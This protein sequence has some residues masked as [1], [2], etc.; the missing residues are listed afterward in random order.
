MNDFPPELIDRISSFLEHDDLKRT[1]FVSP[2]FQVASERHSGAFNSFTFRNNDVD[3]K[4][5]LSTY[6]GRRLPYLRYIEVHTDFPSLQ[7]WDAYPDELPCR[8]SQD[9]LLAKDESF[10]K[11]VQSVFVTIK[12]A[13][14]EASLAHY[15]S[16]KT[17]LTILTPIRWVDPSFCR[18]R[19][20]SAWRVHLLRPQDLPKLSSIRALSICNPE[21]S[22]RRDG[23]RCAITRLDWRVLVDVASRLPNLEYLGS[24]LGIEEWRLPDV[25]PTRR[26]FEYDFEGGARD[27][28]VGFAKALGEMLLPATLRNVQLDF[29][30]DLEEHLHAEEGGGPNLVSPATYDLFSSSL[31]SLAS[32]LRRL[33]LRLK[34]DSALF[35]P[36]QG[37]ADAS[38]PN[39]EFS[40]IMF[41][42]M[43]PSGSWY[44]HGFDGEGGHDIGYPVTDNM[45]PPLDSSNPRD[46]NWHFKDILGI[47]ISPHCF[48]KVPN[49]DTMHAFLEAFAKAA[50]N[51]H[52]LR[53]F[54][55][56]S[57]L[58][59][60]SA[61]GIAYA[62][63]GE[64]ATLYSPSEDFSS[65]RQLWWKVGRWR[66]SASL[67]KLF[68]HIGR[69]GYGE[70][71]IEHWN[72][73]ADD[74]G[75]TDQETF[76]ESLAAFPAWSTYPAWKR[77]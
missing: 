32:N 66:P 29:L 38:F 67:H 6:S 72:N 21:V 30:N 73:E 47:I 44:F 1:L 40:N 43:T 14:N 33:D 25:D 42:P 52:A 48:R 17:Q 23:D 68:Q 5:F 77:L 63:P 12:K 62:R 49:E 75:W 35:W 2:S 8:E 22:T 39:L 27:S 58:A 41:H 76:I 4:A 57:P 10:T 61:W 50:G 36:A 45:Y 26:H 3:S 28:R 15:G 51:M 46:A 11:Q 54:S 55:L 34:A 24:R 60:G 69:V 18:H 13:E 19:V 71:L 70:E 59:Y 7:P 74:S 20:S 9:E 16:G 37:G 65:S 64:Q 56:W 53:A 31:R